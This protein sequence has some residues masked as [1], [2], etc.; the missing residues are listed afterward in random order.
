MG[1]MSLR[2]G[3]ISHTT[4]PGKPLALGLWKKR[5]ESLLW[6]L[7]V[8]VLSLS[9]PGRTKPDAR[10]GEQR[11]A[12]MEQTRTSQSLEAAR[13]VEGTSTGTHLLRTLFMS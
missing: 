8:S 4:R 10:Q 1:S 5:M 11:V 12:G 7:L 13:M 2:R 9:A 6:P 3:H